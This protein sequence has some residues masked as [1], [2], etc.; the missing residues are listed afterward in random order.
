M[1]IRRQIFV[2][3]VPMSLI[4]L[5]SAVFLASA[6]VAFAGWRQYGFDASHTSFNPAE[7]RLTRA[8]VATLTLRWAGEVGKQPCSPPIVGEG[9]VYVG[10]RG[11]VHAFAVGDGSELWSIFSCNGAGR[12]RMSLGKHLFVTDGGPFVS[13]DFAAYNPI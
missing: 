1:K 9:I 11:L 12:E 8:N 13:G 3:G 4:A 2:G 5:A 7:T 6:S 10:A